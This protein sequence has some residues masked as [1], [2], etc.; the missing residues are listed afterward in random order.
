MSLSE[1]LSSIRIALLVL[2]K[3][4]VVVRLVFRNKAILMY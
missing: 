1:Y 2:K 4:S 3:E